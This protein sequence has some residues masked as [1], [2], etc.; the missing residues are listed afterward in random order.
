[1]RY[2]VQNI[3]ASSSTSEPSTNSTE[4]SLIL[5][6]CGLIMIVPLAVIVSKIM[7]IEILAEKNGKSTYKLYEEVLG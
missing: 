5:D 2:P 7:A 3:I 1:M 4:F 6:I